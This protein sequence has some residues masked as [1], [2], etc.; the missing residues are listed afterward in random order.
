MNNRQGNLK[1]VLAAVLV[2]VLAAITPA[3][4]ATA[5][6]GNL[7]VFT[8]MS[9]IA[10]GGEAGTTPGK[11][12]VVMGKPLAGWRTPQMAPLE[13]FRTKPRR[14][15]S[16]RWKAAVDRL[17]QPSMSVISWKVG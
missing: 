14:T 15:S 17:F 16:A 4:A 6:G 9:L 13:S 11:G 8:D 7:Q 3:R 2:M 1:F 5:I 10:L 12:M